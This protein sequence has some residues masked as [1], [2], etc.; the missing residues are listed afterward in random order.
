[1]GLDMMLYLEVP[2][3]RNDSSHFMR[4]GDDFI[5]GDES[6]MEMVV[7]LELDDVINVDDCEF[8]MSDGRLS[9]QVAYWRKVNAIHAWFVNNFQGGV[10]ECQRSEP[11]DAESLLYLADLCDQ[12]IADPS[13]ADELLP[14]RSGFFFGPTD[15]GDYY[16]DRLAYTS[17]TLR[18]VVA[19]CLSNP[20]LVGKQFIYQSSW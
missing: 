1:M 11:V 6:L 4:M 13:K 16:M 17:D 3:D 9:V 12:V 15:Y 2:V 20:K 18:K 8:R 5:V 14:V 19:S 7:D 10:D